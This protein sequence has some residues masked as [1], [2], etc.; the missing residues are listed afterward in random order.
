MNIAHVLMYM[1]PG[2]DTPEHW[3][4]AMSS[5]VQYISDWRLN[6]PQPNM[7]EI[8]AAY[9]EMKAIPPE[10]EPPTLEE[11]VA[12]LEEKVRLLENA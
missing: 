7:E 4:V 1:F 9:E 6:E 5:G 10:P 8:E 12:Q 11:R 3:S 2:T